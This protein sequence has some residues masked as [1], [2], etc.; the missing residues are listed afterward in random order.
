MK[1]ALLIIDPQNDFT[2]PAGSLFV[3][4][5]DQD[6][7]RLSNFIKKESENIEE[8]FVT[9]DSHREVDIAHPVYWK[10]ENGEH[11]QP[12]TVISIE[13]LRSG[14]W[15]AT[16]PEW[17]QRSEEYVKSLDENGKYHLTIWPPHC[18]VGSWGQAVFPELSDQLRQWEK[19]NFKGVTYI[20]KGMNVWTEHY[21]AVKAEVEDTEDP[22]TGLNKGLLEGLKNP[23]FEKILIAGEAL[24]HCVASTVRDIAENIDD[25]SRLVLLK[26]CCSSVPGCESLG[27]AFI[28]DLTLKGM[29]LSQSL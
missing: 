24:S 28:N 25:V 11:P 22:A 10:N 3:P 29:E 9:L 8:I 13:D 26:D 6:M 18:I 19:D 12:F 7:L 2:D 4:G 17:Q 27:E 5:A 14:K 15:Q 16:K 23:A 1:T 21:S 20:N